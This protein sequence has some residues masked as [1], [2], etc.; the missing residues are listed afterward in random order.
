MTRWVH[1]YDSLQHSVVDL[2]DLCLIVHWHNSVHQATL[3]RHPQ[4]SI[5][6]RAPPISG[7]LGPPGTKVTQVHQLPLLQWQISYMLVMDSL[8][9]IGSMFQ[10]LPCTFKCYLQMDL[11]L[12][13][14]LMDRPTD[15]ALNPTQQETYW[16]SWFLTEH[17][18]KGRLSC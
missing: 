9:P 14:P 2:S 13:N 8:S 18:E 3:F 10:A 6:H 16:Q 17:Q 4:H 5:P 15:R 11:V 7:L 1:S 12:L